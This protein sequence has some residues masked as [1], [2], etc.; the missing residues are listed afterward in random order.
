MSSHYTNEGRLYDPTLLRQSYDS[1]HIKDSIKSAS[2]ATTKNVCDVS[3][4]GIDHMLP[5]LIN[6]SPSRQI[7]TPKLRSTTQVDDYMN[8]INAI[9]Q[10]AAL[11]AHF[12]NTIPDVEETQEETTAQEILEAE[13]HR[14]QPIVIQDNQLPFAKVEL[15]FE[16]ETQ[17]TMKTLYESKMYRPRTQV[18]NPVFKSKST[19]KGSKQS[20]IPSTTI[21]SSI[22]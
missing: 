14:G 13:A 10:Q 3:A 22:D 17:T 18:T 5:K 20:N 11:N 21:R 12:N 4:L 2:F 8:K 9:D 7:Q 6:E 1:A 15:K 16:N 19:A